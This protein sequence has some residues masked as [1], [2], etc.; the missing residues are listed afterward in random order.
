MSDDTE[1]KTERWQFTLDGVELSVATLTRS[2]R[3]APVVTLH[4]F[5]ST[6]EDYADFARQGGLRRAWLPRLRRA[7]LRGVHLRGPRGVSVPVPGAHR[8]GRPAPAGIERFHL[9][10]HSM[11]GLTALLLAHR[12]PGRI[13]SFVDIEGNL[14]PEDC[15]L[16]RQIV[17]HPGGDAEKFLDAFADRVGRAPT[18]SSALYAASVR[19]KVRAGAVRGIFESMV[20]LSDHGDL[21]AGFLAAPSP[22]CSCTDSRTRRCRTSSTSRPTA[23]NSPR[24]RPA[25]TGRCRQPRRDVERIAGFVDRA[26]RA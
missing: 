6:K 12:N 11:G 5:G 15:F 26:E 7:G 14:A 21:M 18:S 9:V 22:G 2:G 3:R 10:G 8:R 1:L 25:G 13:L 19:H 23:S 4:G 16:S 20:E 17:H 24:S